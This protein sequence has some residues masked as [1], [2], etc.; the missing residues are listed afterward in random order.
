MNKNPGTSKAAAD[1]L[2]KNIR[3]KTYSAE[4]QIRIVL[5]GFVARRASQR[6]AAVKAFRRACI[7]VGPRNY[8]RQE[9]VVY[10]VIRRAR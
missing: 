9:S 8:W 5:A 7:T 3:S 1:K 6:C 4:E 2:V 10:L